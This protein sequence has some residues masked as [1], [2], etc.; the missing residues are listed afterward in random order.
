LTENN[1]Q[2]NNPPAPNSGSPP[3]FNIDALLP[4][5]MA[6]KAEVIG[7]GKVNLDFISMFALSILAGSFIA[8]GAIF[9]TVAL[10]GTSGIPWGWSRLIAG[11]VFS[12]GLILVVVGG[13]ELFTGNNLVIMAWFD[14]RF[15]ALKLLRSWG[16]VYIGNFVGAVFTAVFVFLSQE[17]TFNGGAVGVTALNIGLAKVNLGFFQA[18]MLGVLCN[19]LVCL[20]VWLSYSAR[21]VTDKVLAIVFPISAFVAAGFEHCIANMYFIPTALFIKTWASP[22]F[23]Q[24]TGLNPQAYNSLTWG[25]FFYNNL[26]PVT[27]GNIFGGVVLVGAI[28]WLIYLRKKS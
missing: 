3:V 11:V 26:L 5:D 14:R 2:D 7:A 19:A 28:Y 13:A 15:S 22:S 20:A 24:T 9:A 10:A 1:S 23:W 12:L 16:I 17:Y 4:K 27:I 8:L 18:F 25:S 6:E 21:T